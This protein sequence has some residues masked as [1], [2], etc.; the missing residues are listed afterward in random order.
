MQIFIICSIFTLILSRHNEERRK[1]YL[2]KKIQSYKSRV[3]HLSEGEKAHFF[4]KLIWKLQNNFYPKAYGGPWRNNDDKL[5]RI[6][7]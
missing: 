7:K 5:A 6:L 2:H 4:R 1:N 3:S